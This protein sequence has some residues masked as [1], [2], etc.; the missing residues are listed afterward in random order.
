MRRPS[1]LSQG[2][3]LVVE[4]VVGLFSDSTEPR[5]Q[6]VYDWYVRQRKVDTDGKYIDDVARGT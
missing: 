1:I 4:K 5:K 2:R 3:I 6:R